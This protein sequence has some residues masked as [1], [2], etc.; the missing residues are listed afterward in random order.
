MKSTYYHT[1][2]TGAV[3]TKSENTPPVALVTGASRGIGRAIALKLAGCGYRLHLVC[4]SNADLLNEVAHEATKRF[5][6]ELSHP[7]P[8][9]DGQ[10]VCTC[11]CGDISD[12]SFVKELFSQISSLDVLVNNA[13]ISVVGLLNDLSDDGWRNLIDTNLSSVFYTCKNAIPLLL[14]NHTGRILNISSVWGN[15]GASTEAAYAAS[16]GGINSLTRSLGKELAPSHIAVNAIACGLID[17]EMNSHLSEEELADLI[18]QIPADRIGT[19]ED[20][21][22]TAWHLIMMPDYLT[23]QILTLD[24]GWI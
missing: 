23:G 17:T 6:S 3:P 8:V 10:I 18:A 5:Q 22:E 13:G 4:R 1:T 12:P 16:K 15:V 20:V 24:G 19:P 14:K 11:H 2:N 21:A 9:P 7:F